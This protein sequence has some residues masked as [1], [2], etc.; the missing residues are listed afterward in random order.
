[1][2][3]LDATLVRSP[4]IIA[5]A[6]SFLGLVVL[7]CDSFAQA[8]SVR[9][10]YEK[11]EVA[12]RVD[13]VLVPTNDKKISGPINKALLVRAFQSLRKD[14]RP[15]YG[16]STIQI[17]GKVPQRAKVTVKIDPKVAK[18]ALIVIA[19]T[20]YT[21][22][23][24][25][26][27]GVRFP[28]HV[29]GVITRKD[30][31]FSSY[32]LTVPLWKA[33][34][35]LSSP[36]IRI[37]LPDGTL[38]KSEDIAARWKKNDK[39]LR[40]QLYGYLKSVDVFTVT[41]VAKLLVTLKVP[42]TD[43]LIPLLGHKQAAVRKV[44]LDQLATVRN[45]KPV[46]QAVL[47]MMQNDKASNLPRAAATFLGESKDKAFAIQKDFFL[48]SS[49]TEEESVA[50]ASV[51]SESKDK[52]VR[53]ELFNRLVDARQPVALASADALARLSAV[54][55]ERKALQS[56]KISP[57]LRLQIAR[58]LTH[59]KN[60]TDRIAG[61]AYLVA[62][63]DADEGISSIK[64]IGAVKGAEAQELLE[65]YLFDLRG[66]VRSA[67]GK[68]LA[69]RKDASAISAIAKA[70]KKGFD[71]VALEEVGY[72]IMISQPL[73][74]IME[75]TKD[76]S[77]IVQRMAYRALGNS[78]KKD[79]GAEIFEVLTSGLSNSDPLIRGA[80]ARSV[81]QYGSNEAVAA[82]TKILSDKNGGVRAD[83]AYGI[84]FFSEGQLIDP[85]IGYL[86][87]KDNRVVAA[88]IEALGR[89]GDA[90]A[91]EQIKQLSESKEPD[92]RANAM[93]A[94]A[95][96]V[97]REDKK[98]VAEVISLLSGGVTDA[99]PDVGKAAVQALG[100]FKDDKAVTA[101][102]IQLNAEDLPLRLIAIEA[103]GATGHPSAVE[104]IGSVLGDSEIKVRRASVAALG[105]L[106]G[107]E[108]KQQ[109][110]NL[111]SKEKDKS[112]VEIIKKTIKSM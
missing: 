83:V 105:E 81:G 39:E 57:A 111:A 96:L 33:L 51:L 99:V 70:I 73:K 31:P 74:T 110:E 94:L 52:R 27:P 18:Y 77:N 98:G 109:L 92:V 24:L 38:R 41:T 36:H 85:L 69:E 13:W 62:N 87:D 93:G 25:G 1:M 100:T 91:W 78:S 12:G 75:K 50:A 104:L 79:G 14:K 29:E 2:L 72:A 86:D 106:K 7:P 21:M 112:L 19:E 26:V 89:R 6:L 30:I 66:Y 90:A 68:E 34:P 53:Q 101:I 47:K 58:D 71:A 17:S 9:Y 20:V 48:L 54:A 16:S 10:S 44:A 107:L 84:G 65:G 102:A 32:T 4:T 8:G 28:G 97:S 5:L 103:L 64:S 61:F 59:G 55:E 60:A 37:R 56:D 15:T 42:F 67:A 49:G 80:S 43:H 22:T 11:V 3:M 82:L 23:E 35:S 108:A 46:L 88:A 45:K 95:A 63:A 40:K 76:S